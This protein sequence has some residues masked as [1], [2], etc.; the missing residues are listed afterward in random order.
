MPDIPSPH[1]PLLLNAVVPSVEKIA[2][3]M[4]ELV[5]I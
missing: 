2:H 5:E 4:R 1:S 3:S